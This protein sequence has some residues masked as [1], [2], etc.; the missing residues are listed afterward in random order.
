MSNIAIDFDDTI[1]ADRELFKLWIEA[2]LDRG[3]N[4]CIITNNY[5]DQRGDI[6]DYGL[7]VGVPVFFAGTMHKS[8]FAEKRGIPVDIW[9]DDH[10]QGI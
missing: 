4:V 10:P 6:I 7:N 2:A 3:H 9:V 8:D 1:D 5:A